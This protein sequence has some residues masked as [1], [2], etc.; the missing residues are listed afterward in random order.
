MKRKAL[1]YQR[2]FKTHRKNYKVKKKE[3][4]EL[5]DDQPSR[6]NFDKED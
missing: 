1:P 6:S 3:K 4:K 5:I 2:S